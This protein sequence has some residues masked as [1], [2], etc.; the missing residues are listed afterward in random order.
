MTSVSISEDIQASASRVWAL[1]GDFGAISDWL[2]AAEASEADG[3]GVGAVRKL[4]LAGGATAD[5]RLEAYDDAGRSYTYTVIESSLPM[6]GY[7]ATIRVEDKG[8]GACTLHWSSTFE[9]V[10]IPEADMAGMIEGSYQGGVENIRARMA[11]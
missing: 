7:R 2:P 3:N 5:E 11:G 9:P 10:G 6:T 1:I 4:S 8:S